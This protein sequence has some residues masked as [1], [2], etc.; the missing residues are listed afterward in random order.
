MRLT[1]SP[2]WIKIGSCLPKFDKIDLLHAISVTFGGVIRS[3]INGNLCRLKINLDVQ[4]P[5]RRGGTELLP[6]SFITS[7]EENNKDGRV[8]RTLKETDVEKPI[9]K[10]EEASITKRVEDWDESKYTKVN[11]SNITKKT[12]WKR[13]APIFMMNQEKSDNG[14][15]KR[16]TPEEIDSC[17]MEFVYDERK[18]TIETSGRGSSCYKKFL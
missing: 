7:M 9:E 11:F 3:E 6:T 17:S 8:Q 2:F 10:Q 12:S 5:L 1:S 15:R 14:P 18:K 13:R 16:K 4:K